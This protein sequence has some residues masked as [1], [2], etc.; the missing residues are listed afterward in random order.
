M[1]ITALAG[2][3][4]VVGEYFQFA[5]NMNVLTTFNT[6]FQVA[7]TVAFPIGLI[8]LF[9][10]HGANVQ[11]KRQRWVL[12]LLLIVVTSIY[13]VVS[14]ITGPRAGT[15][16]DWVYQGYISPAGSTLYGII[17]F[18]I[19]SCTFRTFR[20]R[21]REATVLVVAALFIL[22]AQSPLGGLLW[23]K[24]GT[25]GD[26]IV[27]VPSNAASRAIVLGAYLGGFAT[28]IRVLLGIERAHIGGMA[29]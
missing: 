16:M 9:L 1:L 3:V 15:A 18:V 2:L 27:L 29:K 7:Q 14:L 20:F 24:W 13:L 23:S 5:Q 10:V 19:T 4:V 26:W 28:A 25:I 8:S 21:S 11:R 17:A 22:I 12:S 6:W